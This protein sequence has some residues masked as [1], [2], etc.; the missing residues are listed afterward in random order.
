[1]SSNTTP[2]PPSPSL[3]LT[4]HLTPTPEN[5]LHY[6]AGKFSTL[7]LRALSTSPDSFA[8]K[9]AQESSRTASF[10]TTFLS[11]PGF[12]VFICV[13]H[14]SSRSPSSPTE[15]PPTPP[16]SSISAGEWIGHISLL[17]PI[18]KP[19]YDLPPN[20][21]PDPDSQRATPCGPDPE[22][23]KWHLTALYVDP[24]YRGHGLARQ[25]I[26]NAISFAKNYTPPPPPPPP[27]SPPAPGMALE[28]AILS[29]V[30]GDPSPPSATRHRTRCA[31]L[32]INNK[33]SSAE[34]GVLAM[35]EKVGFKLDGRMALA[36]AMRMNGD[37]ELV[38]EEEGGKEKWWRW[39]A[40]S[41]SRVEE[42]GEGE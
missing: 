21:Y 38:K 14:P 42:R 26:E 25:L 8:S 5:P 2:Q 41:L 31:R 32:R 22:E 9:F 20:V 15:Q 36:P 35:W 11:R 13:R 12:H 27:P 1:M 34:A 37:G 33:G 18:P 10:W 16:P 17:G 29:P 30:T 3:F 4:H 24:D 23:S 6:L 39:Y 40:V 19:T 28:S 7:R